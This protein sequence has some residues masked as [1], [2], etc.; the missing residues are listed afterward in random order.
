MGYA[1]GVPPLTKACMAMN[2]EGLIIET[3]PT[4]TLAKSDASQQLDYKEF[5]NL[6][7]ELQPLAECLGR[8]IR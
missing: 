8:K 7:N 3:H 1:Y 6:Y 2:V 5:R 4:P